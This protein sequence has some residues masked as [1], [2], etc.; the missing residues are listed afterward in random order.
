MLFNLIRLIK[1]HL[2]T[3]FEFNMT[4]AAQ[5]GPKGFHAHQS[6]MV[7]IIQMS[8]ELR[9]ESSSQP[10]QVASLAAVHHHSERKLFGLFA[11]RKRR[12]FGRKRARLARARRVALGWR[13]LYWRGRCFH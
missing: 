11:R 3:K 12:E 9:N 5:N 6:P 8:L 4:N 1:P 2:A 10:N 13:E 7:V